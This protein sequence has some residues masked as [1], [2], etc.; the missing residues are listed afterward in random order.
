MKLISNMN[1]MRV[2]FNS[3]EALSQHYSRMQAQHKDSREYAEASGSRK[4]ACIEAYIE[5]YGSVAHMI[6][7]IRF[8]TGEGRVLDWAELEN[9]IATLDDAAATIRELRARVAELARIMSDPNLN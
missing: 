4:Q 3:L 6:A 8:A 5:T 2:E 9:A 7:N 1:G